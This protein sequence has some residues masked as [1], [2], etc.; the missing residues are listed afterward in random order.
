MTRLARTG[1]PDPA[2]V[3]HGWRQMRPRMWPVQVF[4]LE[5]V[6]I[7]STKTPA[8]AG[9]EHCGCASVQP[10][11]S[12]PA[13]PVDLALVHVAEETA[14]GRRSS[15]VEGLALFVLPVHQVADVP[16]AELELAGLGVVGL[17]L[18]VLPHE[19]LEGLEERVRRGDDHA[20]VLD[21]LVGA[22]ADAAGRRRRQRAGV[23]RRP[24]DDAVSCH[25][26]T[27]LTGR[28]P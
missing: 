10:R 4:G 16:P 1:V 6:W 18:G 28:R 15:L 11:D 8:K 19:G 23:E 26:C 9:L 24:V 25:V 17:R 27:T 13:S 14:R 2:A 5:T 22:L 3:V 21:H 7:S 20:G 12:P